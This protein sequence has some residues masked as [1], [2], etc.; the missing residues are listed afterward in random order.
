MFERKD[1]L[2]AVAE[3]ALAVEKAACTSGSIDSVATVGILD[4]HLHATNSI[5]SCVFMMLDVR[6]MNLARR[7]S[8]DLLRKLLL[9]P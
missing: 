1:T 9:H 4:V 3:I 6:D 7:I 5:P 8:Q 2:L